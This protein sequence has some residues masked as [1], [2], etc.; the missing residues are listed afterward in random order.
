MKYQCKYLWKYSPIF[1][2]YKNDIYVN[3][4]E[5]IYV[6][7]YLNDIYINTL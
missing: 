4:T 1:T 7:I 5:N 3:T 6:N 2:Q